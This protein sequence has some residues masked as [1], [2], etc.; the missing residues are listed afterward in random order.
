MDKVDLK[1]LHGDLYAPPRGR[2]VIV[3]VPPLTYLAVDGAG[4]PNSALAY[5]QAVEALF[6]ASYAVKFA[7]KKQLG[8]DYVVGPLEGL[9]TADDPAAFIRREKASWRWTML[10]L[11][12]DWIASAMVDEAVAR[13]Q[14]TKDL[15]ALELMQ[16]RTLAES[17]SAQTLHIGS[18]DDETPVLDEL[19]NTFMP[20][21]GLTFA[22]PHHEI[23]LSDARR[24][25][26]AKLRTILR[27][28]VRSTAPA[29][30]PLVG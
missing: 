21:H 19:H 7:S 5:A 2:F 30:D 3:D 22:G 4:D 29:G 9:W 10:V 23:Y 24:T 8:R 11:L 15:P 28:P 1:K 20:Q 17:Q 25:D 6:A 18:Y 16:R 14:A 26:P 13:V 12:P 27:Q